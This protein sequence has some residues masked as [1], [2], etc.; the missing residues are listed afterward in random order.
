MK[1][2]VVKSLFLLLLL[3]SLLTS[4]TYQQQPQVLSTSTP[5]YI[6]DS[7]IPGVKVTE[8]KDQT[9]NVNN[10]NVTCCNVCPTPKIIIIP[11][12]KTVKVPIRIPY[13][14]LKPIPRDPDTRK[15]CP[16]D[17]KFIP[18]N[19]CTKTIEINCDERCPLGYT[20]IDDKK[21]FKLIII[22]N[23]NYPPLKKN[24]T[25]YETLENQMK[26]GRIK[27]V[28][29]QDNKEEEDVILGCK[30]DNVIH[31]DDKEDKITLKCPKG[32]LHESPYRCVKVI[33]CPKGKKGWVLLKDGR[34]IRTIESCPKGFIKQGNRC[35][36]KK[37]PEGLIKKG[38]ICVKEVMKCPK[39]DMIF[40][41]EK[42]VCIYKSCKNVKCPKIVKCKPG[43]VKVE[44]KCCSYCKPCTCTAEY[45]PVCSVFGVTVY[46][47]C[48]AKCLQ[49]EI[50]YE[51]ECKPDKN[52]KVCPTCK[53]CEK[54]K[55]NYK[56]VCGKDGVT[57]PNICL[58]KCISEGK[59]KL[60]HYGR[61]NYDVHEEKRERELLPFMKKLG[62]ELKKKH[63]HKK[64]KK[65]ERRE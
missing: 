41:E 8:I 51:G 29:K 15:E 16:K 30:K 31:V 61:C 25:E 53:E 48:T 13:P 38:K 17:Y 59:F 45:Q 33:S 14:V 52:L 10:G 11:K 64:N 28:N 57:W 47:L 62:K 40:D 39:K 44:G 56:P 34:C 23:G 36:E 32:Y 6:V 50:A 46:N 7:K 2:L 35:V 43:D 42:Q 9:S 19:K 5:S 1:I 58:A 26:E 63:H 49:L 3:F 21:C 4:S 37:C 18:P 24:S 22:D 55:N 54:K 20:R 27:L 65:Q 60:K 12:Y